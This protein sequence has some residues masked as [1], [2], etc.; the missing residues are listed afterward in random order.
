MVILLFITFHIHAQITGHVKGIDPETKTE[1]TLAGASV[2]WLNTSIGVLTDASG[3]FSISPVGKSNL[4]VIQFIGYKPDT[5]DVFERNHQ[6]HSHLDIVLQN[7]SEINEIVVVEN[8]QTTGISSIKTIQTEQI[9]SQGL[10]K[11]ACC[12]LSESFENSATVDVSYADAVTGAKQIQMLGLA[13][14]YNQIMIENIPAIRGLST[15]LGLSYIPGTW[16]ESIQISKGSASVI[17]GFESISGQINVELLKPK[18]NDEIL[19]N[20]Y[21]NSELKTE[22]NLVLPRKINNK[23]TTSLL[24]HANNFSNETDHDNDG[25]MDSPKARQLNLLNRWNYQT[26]NVHL[27]FGVN[28][29]NEERQGGQTT[30]AE[31]LP[32]LYRAQINTNYVRSFGKLGFVFAKPGTSIGIQSQY[33]FHEQNALLG[34]NTF[35]AR[36]QSG[37]LN[38]IFQSFINNTAHQ[39]SVGLNGQINRLEQTL[40]NSPDLIDEQSAGLFGQY[41]YIPGHNF[42]LIVGLRAD[43]SNNYRLLST[44]RVHLKWEFLPRFSLRVSAGTAHR[45]AYAIAENFGKLMSNRIISVQTEDFLEKAANVGGHI[46]W[47]PNFSQKRKANLSLDFYHTRFSEQVILDTETPGQL[48][49]YSLNGTSYS[50][51]FQA[52]AYAEPLKNTDL[53]VAYRFNDVKATFDGQL[54]EMPF[55]K[56]HKMVISNSWYTPYK[57][58]QLD[59]TGQLNGVSRLTQHLPEALPVESPTYWIF[60]AQLTRRFKKLELY[61]G[62]ENISN[63]TQTQKIVLANDVDSAYFDASRIWGPVMGRM[64]Y[65]G[66]RYKL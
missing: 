26:N 61:A 57:R 13:G 45:T 62:G 14:N 28:Y 3:H 51:S 27:Q 54:K 9:N 63:Y 18:Q 6:K 5:I 24:A 64:L 1:I 40:N 52:Q 10:K 29:L 55:V 47:A 37:L 59:L 46:M 15:P 23:W 11:L 8:T 50:N 16:M 65:A 7:N 17:N 53:M 2:N 25:F 41:S 39:Y 30:S 42:N 36:E 33:V 22:A 32:H 66:L 31:N 12:N 21:A 19:V 4:L 38:V 43:Y 58:W 60:H 20:V 44:P 35:D 34:S 56:R 48:N 49:I